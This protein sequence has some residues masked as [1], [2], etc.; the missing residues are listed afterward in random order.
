MGANWV[1]RV[2]LVWR[3]GVRDAMAPGIRAT[4]LVVVH[5][6][7]DSRVRIGLEFRNRRVAYLQNS[8]VHGRLSA[9]GRT[10]LPRRRVVGD[11][12]GSALARKILA[13]PSHSSHDA[14]AMN[15]SEIIGLFD[16]YV[17]P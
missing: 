12:L 7:P 13:T 14:R 2:L 4:L 3:A 10:H 9:L 15:R 1:G 11:C 5:G 16:R 17:V 8:A 6:A